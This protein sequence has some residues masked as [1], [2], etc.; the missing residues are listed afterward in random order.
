MRWVHLAALAA[1]VGCVS[2]RAD[3]QYTRWGMSMDDVL[4]RSGG[5]LRRSDDGKSLVGT[6]DVGG[7]AFDA[8][9]FFGLSGERNGRLSTVVVSHPDTGFCAG[10]LRLLQERM[11]PEDIVA[12]A[13]HE[14]YLFRDKERNNLVVYS[15]TE[16]LAKLPSSGKGREASCM[17]EYKPLEVEES[18][19]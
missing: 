9:L 6:H 13:G 1:S 15:N 3:W 12:K 18:G 17:I 16:W 19:L 8:M 4:A 5:K 10:A 14:K 2:A 7:V 11:K